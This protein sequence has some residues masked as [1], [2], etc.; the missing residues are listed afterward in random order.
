MS[1][2]K[3]VPLLGRGIARF[4]NQD[5]IIKRAREIYEQKKQETMDAG[6]YS[7]ETFITEDVFIQSFIEGVNSTF[8]EMRNA[9]MLIA[10]IASALLTAGPDDDDETK[11]FKKTMAK[12]VDKLTDEISFFY[13]PNSFLDIMGTKPLPVFSLITDSTRVVRELSLEVFGMTFDNEEWV[14]SAKP[15]KYI[16]RM[17]PI[18]KE[19]I[20]YI[21]IIDPELGKEMGIQLSNR[22]RNQ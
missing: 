10:L 20:S 1:A 17:F 5:Y 13:S 18:S 15:A 4:E 14:D 3:L 12:L 2:A 8:T 11:N 21:P 7:E 16:F 9:F 19:V 6:L 22:S